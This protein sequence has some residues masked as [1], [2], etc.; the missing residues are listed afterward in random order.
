MRHQIKERKM[1]FGVL[2]LPSGWHR[3]CANEAQARDC[4]E[5]APQGDGDCAVL[6]INGEEVATREP[7]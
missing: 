1:E 5:H 7:D 3:E 4:F 6:I 2:Y